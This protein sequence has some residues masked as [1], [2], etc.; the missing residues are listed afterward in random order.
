MSKRLS[1][2]LR[3]RTCRRRVILMSSLLATVPPLRSRTHRTHA[4]TD[5]AVH[6]QAAHMAHQIERRPCGQSL[7]PST[8]RDFGGFAR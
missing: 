5:A 3:N 7:Q 6:Q 8:Y 1:H 2:D 4:A